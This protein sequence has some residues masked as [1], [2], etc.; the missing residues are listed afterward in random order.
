VGR[1]ARGATSQ[2]SYGRAD[3]E[4]A[5]AA[6][7]LDLAVVPVLEG[8][9]PRG[10]E[11]FVRRTLFRDG[12]RCFLRAGHPALETWS[13]DGWLAHGH[14]LVAPSG[15]TGGLVD[16]VL[17]EHGRTRTVAV[18]VEGFGVV[19]ELIAGTD[20]IVTAPTSLA[21]LTRSRGVVDRPPPIALPAHGIA[22]LWHRRYHDDPSLG[23]L[24]AQLDAALSGR[25]PVDVSADEEEARA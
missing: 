3:L 21:R 2:V 12:F 22:L 25:V 23:W 14:L 16:A 15:R 5:L 1:V 4:D 10:S 11:A 24:M 6:G 19:P 7:D 9:A 18:Q 17:A 13:L 20:L 8:A